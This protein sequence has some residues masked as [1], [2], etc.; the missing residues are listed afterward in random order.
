MG[1][2][3]PTSGGWV[4]VAGNLV[5]GATFTGTIC[6]F[7]VPTGTASGSQVYIGGGTNGISSS[8]SLTVTSGAM[9]WHTEGIMD[10]GASD[11]MNPYVVMNASGK[12]ITVWL[13]Y[14]GVSGWERLYANSY[15]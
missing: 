5:G 2:N 11:V 8:Y 10:A 15:Y 3:F 6:I 7:T 14:D 1:T 9:A 13:Q 12:A 4:S